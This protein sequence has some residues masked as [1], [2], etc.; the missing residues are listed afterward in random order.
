MYVA[1][2]ILLFVACLVLVLGAS[3]FLAR[4][5]DRIGSKLHLTDELVG[6]L[7]ALGA[8]SPE[9]SSAIVA[10]LSSRRDL[11]VG[12]VLG[13]NLFNLAALLG[14][15]AVVAGE[16]SARSRA[17]I[18]NGSVAVA[19]TLVAGALINGYLSP[20]P[21]TILMLLII[22]PYIYILSVGSRGVERMKLP[23]ASKR[24]LID[25][26]QETKRE[27]EEIAEQRKQRERKDR[28]IRK[29]QEEQSW[30]PAL[31]V[32]PA[33]AVIVLGSIGLIKY[34]TVLGHGWLPEAVLGTFVLASLTGLPNSLTAVRLARNGNGAAVITETFNSNTINLLVG[35]LLPALIFGEGSP[36]QLVLFDIGA[37]VLTTM[38]AVVLSAHASK[39]TRIQGAIVIALY[40]AFIGGWI[41]LFLGK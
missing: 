4:G 1:V 39:L 18:F 30:K 19:V 15:G 8:D 33:L 13:S 32:L 25:A 37:L 5:I 27:T 34:A 2:E 16:V 40:L 29:E 12:I 11:G 36:D 6:V 41:V 23:G 21:A 24:F 20:V 3:E 26:T 9:I 35:L 38:V 31:W 10:L 7:T 28:A 14:L 17:T 22:I